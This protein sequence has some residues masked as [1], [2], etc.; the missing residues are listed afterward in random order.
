MT[1]A[2]GIGAGQQ[3]PRRVVL[4]TQRTGCAVDAEQAA[5]G[6]VLQHADLAER[7][8]HAGGTGSQVVIECGGAAVGGAAHVADALHPV[9]VA[10]ADMGELQPSAVT[11]VDAGQ[12]C[13]L[14]VVAIAG[15]V[16]QAV[17]GPAIL[18]CQVGFHLLQPA[19]CIMPITDGDVLAAGI[20]TA[21]GGQAAG[22]IVDVQGFAAGTGHGTQP[23][24]IVVGKGQ[25]LAVGITD[26]QQPAGGIVVLFALA[27]AIGPHAGAAD[28]VEAQQV[29]GTAAAAVDVGRAAGV[30]APHQL[31]TILVGPAHAA[32]G[33]IQRPVPAMQPAR[34]AKAPVV[35][36]VAQTVVGT[37][38]FDIRADRHPHV[39]ASS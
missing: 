12:S 15:Q 8:G 17:V 33:S 21:Q 29:I 7:V 25:R 2:G 36:I 32:A 11:V 37:Q 23:A 30:V 22:Q 13:R 27:V 31:D 26:R 35:A 10:D 6:I 14:A 18:R 24:G 1:V 3:A 34:I 4:V 28:R 38:Q 5:V 39:V 20:R 9:A 16:H 19:G